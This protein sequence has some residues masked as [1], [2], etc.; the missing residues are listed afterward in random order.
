MKLYAERLM[1]AGED[2]YYS[3][4]NSV[5][6]LGVDWWIVSCRLLGISPA[7]FV[8]MLV[9]EYHANIRYSP[10]IGL[11]YFWDG[12]K[13]DAQRWNNFINQKSMETKIYL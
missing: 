1:E 2:R 6:P 4:G 13:E 9:N 3:V 10:I 5:T 11:S 8:K 7:A 12:N